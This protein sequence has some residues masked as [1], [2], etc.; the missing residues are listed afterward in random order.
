MH[1]FTPDMHSGQVIGPSP[2]ARAGHCVDAWRGAMV[3]HGGVGGRGET[4]YSE[5]QHVNGNTVWSIA[6]WK[7]A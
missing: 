6:S 1:A 4:Y 2:A 3:L 5:C 7:P